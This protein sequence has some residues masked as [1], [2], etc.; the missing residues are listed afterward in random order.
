VVSGVLKRLAARL[1]E[2]TQHELR[3]LFFHQQ[4]RKNRF[5]TDEQEYK[6]LGR[7]IA[8]GDWVLDI[9]ANV[10]HYALR[11]SALVGDG[12]RVIA[13]EPVP[14]TFALLAAN[15][16]LFP[17]GNVSLINAAVSDHTGRLGMQIPQFSKGLTN[18]YQAR[19]TTADAALKILTLPVDALSLPAV[20]LAKIDVEG[21]ELPALRGMRRLIERDHPVLIVETGSDETTDLIDSFGYAIERL[22]G[23]SNVLCVQTG[24]V[25]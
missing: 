1:P 8:P 24:S 10:G 23:S 19:I 21:H 13:F 4:I 11:M 7:F 25:R 2:A 14:E 5:S 18:Y 3:R 20:K 16:R 12:G 22:P 17:Y 15:A 6:L 9:G